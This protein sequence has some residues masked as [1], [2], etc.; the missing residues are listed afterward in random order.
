LD[1]EG[2]IMGGASETQAMLSQSIEQLLSRLQ[3]VKF[4]CEG[5]PKPDLWPSLVELGL[6]LAELPAANGGLELAFADVAPAFQKIGQALA[7]TYLAEFS[8]IGGWMV[9]ACETPLARDVACRLASGEARVGLAFGE[10]GDGG[11]IAFTRTSAVH[12][13]NDWQ[14]DGTKAVVV[15]GDRATHLIIPAMI[16]PEAD[17]PK[18]ELALFLVPTET[19]GLTAHATELYDGSF[20]ADFE[21]HSLMVPANGLLARGS[22]AADL[23]EMALD[24][25]RAALCHE[26]VGLVEKVNEITLDYVKTRN[27][28]G[29]P[30]GTFQTMQHRMADMHMDLELAQSCAELATAA[31]SAGGGTNERMQTISAAMASICD[32]ARRVGQS[33]VQ[34]HGGIALTREY[35]VGHYFKRLTL[36][37]RYLGNAEFHLERY[38]SQA[39]A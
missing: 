18:G 5:K 21:L 33:A 30:I 12:A 8:V 4:L 25:G 19:A 38:I 17:N 13:E 14:I 23:L 11:D 6:P 37:E 3:S 31:I 10:H 22:T 36:V 24:R 34:A 20:G 15:G 2:N 1:F 32:C 16:A 27:Q 29:Q 28:F 9:A 26:T 35:A 39:E 7:T